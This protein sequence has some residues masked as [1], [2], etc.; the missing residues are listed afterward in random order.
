M[1]V[2]VRVHE[3]ES[4]FAV[5]RGGARRQAAQLEHLLVPPRRLAAVVGLPG[6][7]AGV[8]G[9]QRRALVG[10]V[11]RGLRGVPVGHVHRDAE[12][13]RRVAAAAVEVGAHHH[14]ARSAVAHADA[15]LDL[16]VTRLAVQERARHSIHALDVVGV[17]ALR[18]PLAE[19]RRLG[20][21]DHVEQLV[22]LRVPFGLARAGQGRPDADARGAGGRLQAPRELLGAARVLGLFGHVQR[23]TDE[24]ERLA[25]RAALDHTPN[26]DVAPRAVAAPVPHLH[27][28]RHAGGQRMGRRGR[29]LGHVVGV[30]DGARLGERQATSLVGDAQHLEAVV[31]VGDAIRLQVMPPDH[32][33]GKLADELELRSRVVARARE[34]VG[35]GVVDHDADRAL[36][37]ALRRVLDLPLRMNPAAAAVGP[38]HTVALR[39]AAGPTGGVDV[40]GVPVFRVDA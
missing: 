37:R 28:D 25:G 16:E 38:H 29:E 32:D 13:P 14:P 2:V 40:G 1:P 12:H 33:V 31:V 8:A 17:N 9:D 23:N 18:D 5:Q 39:V 21:A 20:R 7:D 27:V 11:Q 15:E 30:G 10:G 24:A 26:E 3:R 22:H 35:L 6:A 36:R 4:L 34:L 19:R